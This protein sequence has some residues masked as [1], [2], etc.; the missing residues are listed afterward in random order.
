M[1]WYYWRNPSSLFLASSPFLARHFPWPSC[2]SALVV[3]VYIDTGVAL[4]ILITEKLSQSCVARGEDALAQTPDVSAARD[5][6]GS[7]GRKQTP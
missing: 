1:R 4:T 6:K 5:E 7:L 2:L 3:P